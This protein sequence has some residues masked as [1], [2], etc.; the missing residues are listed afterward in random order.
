LL[1][2]GI[3]AV[4]ENMDQRVRGATDLRTRLGVPVLGLI[5]GIGGEIDR[6]PSTLVAIDAPTSEGADAFR[7]LRTNLVA[8]A[9]EIGAR[10]VAITSI[11]RHDVPIEFAANL[12]AV[13]ATTGKR[14]VLLSP[15]RSEPG[16]AELLGA[17]PG[18]GF[19]DA[20]A[21]AVPI[22]KAVSSTGVDNL[23]LCGPWGGPFS[24]SRARIAAVASATQ[25][26]SLGTDRAAR[27][28]EDL[29]ASADFLLV[30]APP[31]LGDPDGA[32]LAGACDG[33]LAVA[34]PTT[35][36]ED[37]AQAC[38]Q[39]ERVRARLFGSVLLC[40]KKRQR[41][42]RIEP[43]GSS[44]ATVPEKEHHKRHHLGAHHPSTTEQGTVSGLT[45]GDAR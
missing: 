45:G 12:A 44:T 15:T 10:S 18:P 22:E 39:L 27:L 5:P 28:I 14:V 36:R 41:P 40:P 16:L 21:G 20:L 31:L 38:E 30:D 34:R 2:F 13:L 7:R 6:A 19:F 33:V 8:G 3:A 23:F 11:D 17:Q 29:A 43:F 24:A 32:V 9:A 42:R 35:K 25:A 37:V 1:G 4:A 26:Q